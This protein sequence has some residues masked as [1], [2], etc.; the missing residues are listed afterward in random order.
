[1]TSPSNREHHADILFDADL[2]EV[3]F[4]NR[5]V[6]RGVAK[7]IKFKNVNFKYTIF[8]TCYLRLCAFE[9]CDFTGCRF[10][11]CN[12][13]GSTF[14][15]CRFDYA[16]FERSQI[17]SEILDTNCPG[18]ENLKLKFA[19]TLRTNFQS[20]GDAEAVNKAIALELDATEAHLYK[21]WKAPES[22]Y[23]SKYQGWNRT[24]VFLQW[25]SFKT[26]D[27]IWGNGESAW[28]LLRAVS[29]LLIVMAL[30]HVLGFG[31]PSKVSE[32]W[33]AI[34]VMPQVLLGVLKPAHYPGGYLAA[35]FL[36]RL[37]AFGFFMTIFI[38]RFNKR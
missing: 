5:L 22:Y 30:I 12:L 15:N 18:W 16:V 29:V 37:I 21:A 10:T 33:S 38:K 14:Q 28:K 26:L 4:S 24:K 6:I 36:L 32:Y 27:L 2:I 19:R 7:K 31:D 11:G 20:L 9:D 23:R 35:I 34:W 3:D 25:L 8:D 1:M 17:T 13:V